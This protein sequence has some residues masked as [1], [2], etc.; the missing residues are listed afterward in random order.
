MRRSLY[1]Y[2]DGGIMRHPKERFRSAGRKYLIR[3]S[4]LLR[5]VAIDTDG[6]ARKRVE[7]KDLEEW[8]ARAGGFCKVG[9]DAC[10]R[11]TL[12][13]LVQDYGSASESTLSEASDAVADMVERVAFH[14]V[15]LDDAA[16]LSLVSVGVRRD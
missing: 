5:N 11:P 4:D 9:L 2:E 8:F 10:T 6:E 7:S 15:G 1:S 12:R 16:A 3:P 14:G 13:H